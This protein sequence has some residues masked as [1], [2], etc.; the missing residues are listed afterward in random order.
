MIV[1]SSV[2]VKINNLQ[3][4][5]IKDVCTSFQRSRLYKVGSE[6]A[7]LPQ[8]FTFGFCAYLRKSIQGYNRLFQA[9][10]I[11]LM[12][13]CVC[14]KSPQS[15]PTLILWTVAHQ[16]PLSIAFSRQESWSGLPCP[17]PGGSFRP[18]DGACVF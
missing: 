3:N 12:C 18:R 17:S 15:C 8:V 14:A 16:A 5:I 1:T 2:P 9:R 11:L 10:T 4:G 13:A 6:D 7:F